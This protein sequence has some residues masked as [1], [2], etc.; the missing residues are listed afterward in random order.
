MMM[1]FRMLLI[2]FRLAW[3]YWLTPW[4]SPLLRWRIETYGITDEQNRLLHASDITPRRF[5]AFC[6]HRR[7]AL[8][9]FLHWAASL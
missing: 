9:R 5:L 6:L 3:P 4:R 1:W 8:A 7:S 2:A